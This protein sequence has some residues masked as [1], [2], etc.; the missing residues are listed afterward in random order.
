MTWLIAGSLSAQESLPAEQPDGNPFLPLVGKSY[1]EYHDDYRPPYDTIQSRSSRA[2]EYLRMLG[3]AAA[4]DPG[5]EWDFNYRMAALQREL[6][7]NRDGYIL[8]PGHDIYDYADR[9]L[10]LA[11][12]AGRAGL[13][14]VRLR[15][16]S[17]AAFWYCEF[18]RDY[19]RSFGFYLEVA[20]ALDTLTTKEFPPRPHIYRKIGEMYHSFREW[21]DAESF[22][23][24]I[25][26]DPDAPANYYKSHY[27]ALNNLG[28]CYRYGGGD[29]ARS[30]SCFH[31]LRQLTADAGHEQWVWNG[32]AEA[33]LGYNRYFQEDY[34]GAL[35]LLKSAAAKITR[36]N[37]YPFLSGLHTRIT[38]IY[39]RRNDLAAAGLHLQHAVAYHR[40]GLRPEKSLELHRVLSEYYIQTDQKTLAS[41]HLD[42]VVRASQREQEAFSGLVL[43]RVEQQLRAADNLLNEERLAAEQIRT[44]AFR[45][46][47]YTV[48]GALAAITCLLVIVA[49]LYRRKRR[50]YRELV[51]RS[52]QWAGVIPNQYTT[53]ELPEEITIEKPDGNRSL[54]E[55]SLPSGENNGDPD[56]D[57]RDR[58]IME[59]I[60]KAMEERELY[61]RAD[62]TLDM[63]ADEIRQNRYYV[64]AALNHCTGKNFNAYVNEYR[65]KEAVRIIS[66]PKNR[67]LTT[68]AIAFD[69]GFNDRSGFY[70]VFKKITGLSPTDFRKNMNG[71]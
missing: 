59:E 30:D 54:S 20:A 38:D 4:A 68:D 2:H 64:S 5:G 44:Q 52:Q 7:D 49:L 29:Y 25:A 62:L 26:E 65:V 35:A 28:L 8:H 46:T 36:A 24:R 34:E 66:D 45:R 18:A 23:R 17:D 42:S 57:K 53:E 51:R 22:Y 67:N 27:L 55:E 21:E 70:R 40:K 1:G 71:K 32:I 6:W 3:E 19:E 10:A 9:M 14:L 47:A 60:K 37:D 63:L 69:A 61:K 56:I 41:A 16:M 13:P 15:A 33:N 58:I 39:L 50:A 43:R 31:A 48:T 12:E 11:E